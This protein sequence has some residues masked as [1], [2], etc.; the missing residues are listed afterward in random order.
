M[1]LTIFD[2]PLLTPQYKNSSEWSIDS[3][4]TFVNS[5]RYPCC[6]NP[7]Q[8]VT[9]ELVLSRKPWFY[10]FNIITP[11]LLLVVTLLFGFLLPP[12]SGERICLIITILLAVALFLELVNGSLPKNSDTVPMLALFFL[13]IMVGSFLSLVAT[14]FVLVVHYQYST[15]SKPIPK[16][17]NQGLCRTIA[18]YLCVERPDSKDSKNADQNVVNFES[19]GVQLLNIHALKSL[20]EKSKNR[21]NRDPIQTNGSGK[22]PGNATMRESDGSVLHDIL[23]KLMFVTESIDKKKKEVKYQNDWIFLGRIIDRF[24]FVIFLVTILLLCALVFGPFGRAG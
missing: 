9:V 8:D 2:S 10:V 19:G 5:Y 1:N 24:C 20:N 18:Y 13:V 16:W 23:A 12:E 14:C 4:R 11:T 15:S 3:A 21:K 22:Q 6:T 17:I 7:F